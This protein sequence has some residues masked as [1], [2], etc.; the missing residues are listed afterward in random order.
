MKAFQKRNQKK[1]FCVDIL[2]YDYPDDCHR[3]RDEK[4]VY[5]FFMVSKNLKPNSIA[6]TVYNVPDDILDHHPLS[7]KF[8]TQCIVRSHED[9]VK[10]SDIKVTNEKVEETLKALD[11]VYES[12]KKPPQNQPSTHTLSNKHQVDPLHFN[13]HPSMLGDHQY[14]LNSLSSG[15]QD[16]YLPPPSTTKNISSVLHSKNNFLPENNQPQLVVFNCEICNR[17]FSTKHGLFIHFGKKENHFPCKVRR[18][19]KHLNLI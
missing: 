19:L 7:M 12:S 6:P 13:H 18:K 3:K 17:T 1:K 16:Y 10:I 8:T 11:D 9:Q 5:D 15:F 2:F 14:H 4:N